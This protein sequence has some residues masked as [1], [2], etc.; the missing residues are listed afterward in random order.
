MAA[1]ARRTGRPHTAVLS[2]EL[3]VETALRLLDE[4]G[5]HGAGMRDIAREL[6]VRP[7]ALYNHVKGK[8]D[9]VD[10]IREL[11]SDRFDISGFGVLPWDRAVERWARS[12]LGSFA[13]HPPTIALL[14]VQPLATGSRTSRMYDTVCAGLI[15]AG[16]PEGRAM[17]IVVALECFIL[18]SALDHAAPDD[19][20]DPGEDPHVPVF[21][22]AYDARDRELDGRRPAEASFELGL[23]AMLTGLRAEFEA[24][25]GGRDPRPA[26]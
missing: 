20:L 14:G 8:E 25:G 21:R 2:R 13:A 7:S 11:V 1:T 17:Q 15:E 10:G 6:G 24:L 3:I 5:E 12:Y 16:W 19:M 26:S 18:G 23:R 22:A 9:V 4:R